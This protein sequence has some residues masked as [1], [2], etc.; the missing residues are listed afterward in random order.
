MKKL[1]F[2]TALTFLSLTAVGVAS[3]RAVLGEVFTNTS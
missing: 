3:E 2:I 1:M